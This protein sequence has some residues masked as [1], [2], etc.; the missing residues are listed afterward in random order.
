MKRIII[1]LV[2]ALASAQT[3]SA[4]VYVKVDAQ[5]NAVGGA[6][7][8]D[9]A[10]CGSGSAYSKA[11]LGPGES[12]AL[13]GTG[14]SGIGNNN[15]GTTVKVDLQT[16]DWTVT[17][18]TTV[19]LPEPIKLV[20]KEIIAVTTQTTETFNPLQPII[21]TPVIKDTIKIPTTNTTTITTGS[22][23]TVIDTQT[24]IVETTTP[25]DYSTLDW[26]TIDWET[27]NWTVFWAWF[28]KW[29]DELFA[30]NL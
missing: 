4:D 6:I 9:A 27:V 26:E 17:R 25:I 8:C 19:T 5:G 20:D 14:D 16:N 23:T 2:I 22:T 28:Q 11:T 10:T 13:Q 18:S 21:S 29:F 3:A 15:P 1:G 12:Y 24:P 30:V 7:M